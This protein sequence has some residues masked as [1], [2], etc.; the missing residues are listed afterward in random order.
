MQKLDLL[1]K[2]IYVNEFTSELSLCDIDKLKFNALQNYWGNYRVT[3]NKNDYRYNYFNITDDKHV[4]WLCDYIRDSWN[5]LHVKKDIKTIN[6]KKHF[7]IQEHNQTINTH[8]H[9]DYL[10]VKNCPDI[11]GIY[12]IG[13]GNEPI[14]LVVQNKEKGELMRKTRIPMKRNNFIFW[15]SDLDFYLDTNTNKEPL[16]NLIFSFKEKRLRNN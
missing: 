8:N 16:I 7:I 3:D 13:L 11:T 15:N 14:D 2:F 5:L 9:F 6:L 1:N 4:M 10:D 12:T